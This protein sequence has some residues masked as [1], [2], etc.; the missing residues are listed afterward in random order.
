MEF[1]PSQQQ[2]T[3]KKTQENRNEEQMYSWN[4]SL[5]RRQWGGKQDFACPNI[6]G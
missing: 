4:K 5:E 6:S 1:S 2:N 3:F